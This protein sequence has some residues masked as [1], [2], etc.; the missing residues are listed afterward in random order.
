MYVLI[1][2]EMKTF[3]RA[4]EKFCRS[5]ACLLCLMEKLALSVRS[6]FRLE[7]FRLFLTYDRK[8][9]ITH[10]KLI[11]GNITIDLSIL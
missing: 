2:K 7:N 4:P 1:L 10:M 11:T 8:E 5:L 3:S 9:S 6:F